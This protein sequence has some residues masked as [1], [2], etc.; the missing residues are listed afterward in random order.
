[1]LPTLPNYNNTFYNRRY[2]AY[3]NLRNFNKIHNLENIDSTQESRK[4]EKQNIE[5]NESINKSSNSKSDKLN[6]MFD[7]NFSLFKYIDNILSIVDGEDLIIIGVLCLLYKSDSQD[8]F[9]MI[10]LLLLL[11]DI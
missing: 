8:I 1:M 5:N 7:T 10:A 11:F 4:K 3:N 6:N 2:T 9:L